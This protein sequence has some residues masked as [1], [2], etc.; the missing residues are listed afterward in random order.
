[1]SAAT[2]FLDERDRQARWTADHVQRAVLGRLLDDQ[3]RLTFWEPLP[4][5]GTTTLIQ[6]LAHW[7]HGQGLEVLIL[8]D[9]QAF[10]RTLVHRAGLPQGHGVGLSEPKIGQR[11]DVLLGDIM[12]NP[13]DL[14]MDQRG[15]MLAC[16]ENWLHAIG[17]TGRAAI[18]CPQWLS[19][20]IRT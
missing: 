20:G 19:N 3:Q 9:K 8:A 14:S 17:G 12:W 6:D 13:L 11:C 1:V 18:A 7:L 5:T 2:D 16:V 4:H 10:A 15:F